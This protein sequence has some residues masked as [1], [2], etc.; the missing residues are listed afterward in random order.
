MHLMTRPA[1]ALAALLLGLALAGCGGDDD[2][3]AGDRPATGQTAA[4]AFP[5]SVEHKF[6]TTRIES[7]PERVVTVGYTDQDPVL[8]LGRRPGRRGGLP[9]RL[10][11]A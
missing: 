11:V 8:A 5:V 3:A 1:A 2:D 6:G 9:R 4:A 10:Q 7:E